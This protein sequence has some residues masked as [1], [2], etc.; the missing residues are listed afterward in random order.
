MLRWWVAGGT[1]GGGDARWGKKNGVSGNVRGER[2]RRH[3][4]PRIN[5]EENFSSCPLEPK[6]QDLRRG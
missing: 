1:G 6:A 2:G 4:S 5:F 3:A